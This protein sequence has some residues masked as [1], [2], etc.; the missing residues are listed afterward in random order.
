MKVGKQGSF[1]IWPI[2]GTLS[3]RS[4]R[5][6]LKEKEMPI[7]PFG[8]MV[9][10]AGDD[11][12]TLYFDRVVF[13]NTMKKSVCFHVYAVAGKKNLSSLRRNTFTGAD[14]IIFMF[15]SR[16]SQLDANIESLRELKSLAG[17]HLLSRIPM[18]V[19]QNKVDLVNG[20]AVD[21]KEIEKILADEGVLFDQGHD[22]APHN[23]PVIP[24]ISTYEN[25]DNVYEVFK[26]CIGMTGRMI[27]KARTRR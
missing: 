26:Q 23:P 15:D 18:V 7:K 21:A 3:Q 6:W 13:Q 11:G 17:K 24:G 16:R 20:D 10:I 14:G 25:Q 27:S 12:S 4:S 5:C 1:P 22:L 19:M 9:K 2:C 8:N